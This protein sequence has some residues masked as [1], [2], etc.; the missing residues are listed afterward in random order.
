MLVL[1][2]MKNQMWVW[3]VVLVVVLGGAYM[4][5]SQLKSMLMGG[6]YAPAPA[7]QTSTYGNPVTSS[8]AATG[9]DLVMT[10]TSAAKGDYLVGPSGMT[11]YIFDK[12]TTGVSNCTGGCATLWPP[13]TTA[14]APATL[15]ANM[16]TFAR[17]DGSMQFAYNGKPLYYYTPDKAVGDVT[18]DG[19]GG[20]WHLVKP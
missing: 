16:T 3:V 1:K 11:L 5:R 15:P 4:Y 8:P 10:K 9:S 19:V 12:D 20:V 17:A 6:A 2:Y 13:Y 18:G 14:A 7:T